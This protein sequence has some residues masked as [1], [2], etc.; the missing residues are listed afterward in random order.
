MDPGW[1]IMILLALTSFE[2]ICLSTAEL[3][4]TAAAFCARRCDVLF[5]FLDTTCFCFEAC[6]G[7][8]AG[9]AEFNVLNGMGWDG[10]NGYEEMG[11]G[12]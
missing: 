11:N 7:C 2:E 10:N 1:Q 4:T 3:E 6:H 5:A 9:S 12:Y 8:D